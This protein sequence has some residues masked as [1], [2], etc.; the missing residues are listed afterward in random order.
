[1]KNDE[2]PTQLPLL[3]RV[4]EGVVFTPY[5]R[6]DNGAADPDRFT[7]CVSSETRVERWFGGEILDHGKGSVDLTRFKKGLALRVVDD[8]DG[9]HM[10]GVQVG[11]VED[12]ELKD[13]KLYGVARFSRS[14]KAQEVKQDILDGIRGAVSVGYRIRNMVLEESD[15]QK[16]DTYRA[17]KWQPQEVSLVGVPADVV[18]AFERSQDQGQEAVEI[19]RAAGAQTGARRMK[20]DETTTTETPAARVTGGE[21]AAVQAERK[22]TSDILTLGKKHNMGERAAKAVDDGIS[23]DAFRQAVLDERYGRT[24]EEVNPDT[25]PAGKHAVTLTGKEAKRYSVSRA[26]LA[27]AGIRDRKAKADPSFETDIHEEIA[28]RLGEPVKG[29]FYVPAN[30][31]V[32][33]VAAEVRERIMEALPLQIRRY[34]EQNAGARA[35]L[36]TATA[37]KGQELK[38]IE[39]GSFIELLRNRMMVKALGAR[40]L[41]GLQSDVAFPR[42]TGAGSFSWVPESP[43]ADVATSNLLL[44]R[45][46]L[47]PKI[48]QSNTSYSRKLLVQSIP[49]IDMLV[50]EDLAAINA[51]GVD[52]AAINGPGTTTPTGILNTAGIGSVTLGANGGNVTYDF[53]VDLETQIAVANA[54]LG[55]MAYLTTPQQRGKLKKVAQISASTGIPV[56]FQNE[57]NGYAAAASNQVPSNLTKGTSTTICHA[58]IL[59]NWLEVLIGQWGELEIIA[60]PYSLKKRGDIEVTTFLMVDVGLRHPASFAAI[61]DAL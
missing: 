48:G 38:F 44:D 31:Q 3:H 43:T 20:P 40:V 35:A 46:T 29:D 49:S 30:L 60:D 23:V 55:A 2:L 50:R 26:I 11:V 6:A 51:L 24:V 22:R 9:T 45:L 28:G 7:V 39:P 15:K 54:D 32:D 19:T 53:M 5:M 56:W 18:A 47:S 21:D 41:T 25:P 57:V 59:G 27:A 13:G 14:A 8:L 12:P 1:M 17:M 16:G 36:D 33:P 10:R 61:K 4:M 42:Q 34:F 52:L 37:T 58:I